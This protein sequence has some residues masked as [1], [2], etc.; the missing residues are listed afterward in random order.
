VRVT[1]QVAQKLYRKMGFTSVGVRKGYYT[2][3]QEDALIMW[4]D[5]PVH[6]LGA[7]PQGGTV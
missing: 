6:S 5:L 2:D 4:A 7:K 1:N 3:N